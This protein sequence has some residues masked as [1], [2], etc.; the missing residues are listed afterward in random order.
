MDRVR[1]KQVPF[2]WLGKAEPKLGTRGQKFIRFRPET[3]EAFERASEVVCP[4]TAETPSRPR[5][6]VVDDVMDG[7]GWDGRSRL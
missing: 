3:I 6:G 2:V 4:A 7:L 1:T 5:R